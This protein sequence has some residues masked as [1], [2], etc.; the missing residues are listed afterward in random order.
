M[1]LNKITFRE[2]KCQKK[3]EPSHEPMKHE[4]E[5]AYIDSIEQGREKAVKHGDGLYEVV[6][7]GDILAEIAIEDKVVLYCTEFV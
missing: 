7:D 6:Q 3:G 1:I 5:I 2:A 4:T